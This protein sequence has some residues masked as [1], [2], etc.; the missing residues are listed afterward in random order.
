MG[1]DNVCCA[2]RE[3]SSACNTK[4]YAVRTEPEHL[5]LCGHPP[6]GKASFTPPCIFFSFKKTKQLK[7]WQ[8]CRSN[9]IRG[10]NASSWSI[11]SCIAGNSVFFSVMIGVILFPTITESFEVY[12]LSRKWS[13]KPFLFIFKCLHTHLIFNRFLHSTASTVVLFL[14]LIHK[15]MKI[16]KQ[17]LPVKK[18]LCLLCRPISS[19]SGWNIFADMLQPMDRKYIQ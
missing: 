3:V 13:K 17:I 1:H 10:L 5:S 15:K 4:H 11:V 8:D 2:I 18:I 6:T 14:L 9:Q 16:N 19:D 12:I 7:T